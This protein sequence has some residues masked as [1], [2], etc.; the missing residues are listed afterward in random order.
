MAH[1]ER[2]QRRAADGTLLR[3]Y[4]VRW[5]GPDGKER[6]KTFQ[7]KVEADRFCAVVS[8][9]L[10]KGQ[11]VDPDAGKIPFETYARKWIEAQTFEETTREAVELRMR[12]HAFPIL[13][14][15]YLSEIQ[16]STI[17]SWL[18]TLA[19][20]A[21]TYRK[22]VFANVSTVFTAAVDDELLP[23]NPCKAPSV[24]K[25]RSD[26]KKLV[27]WSRRRV[28]A[29]RDELPE[30]YQLVA[31][32]GAGL[33]LRQGEI[34]ALSPDDIDFEAGEVHVRRQVKLFSSNRQVFGLPK[35]RK[36]RKVPL[37]DAVADAI[38]TSM[39]AHPPVEITLPWMVLD[40]KPTT[41]SLLLPTRERGA[42]N[43]NYFNTYIWRPALTRAGVPDLRENGCHA[44]RHFFASTALHEGETIRAVS[45][46]LGHADPGFTLR[47]YTH[48]MEGSSERTKRAIDTAFLGAD[49][50]DDDESGE[51]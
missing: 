14:D 35:G 25:P 49:E 17:Q 9:D 11:Y 48:L 37:P 22:V 32:L 51:E 30:R 36:T 31:W 7:K 34:F 44:L 5:R 2:R 43:R 21:P 50:S 15:R 24:R 23:K 10:V 18:R 26:P 38:S 8:A 39:T 3:T 33:G 6:N 47:T 4:R 19:D 16:P 40:G 41:V 27:P 45:E 12:L 20:L 29:V 13:G 46:Y 28:L 1:V 42:L